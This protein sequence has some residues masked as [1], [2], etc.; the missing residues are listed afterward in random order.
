MGEGVNDME[1]RKEPWQLAWEN[2]YPSEAAGLPGDESHDARNAFRCGYIAAT[3][4]APAV[5]GVVTRERAESPMP[6]DELCRRLDAAGS[7][8]KLDPVKLLKLIDSIAAE[9]AALSPPADEVAGLLADLVKVRDA[10]SFSRSKLQGYTLLGLDIT[11]ALDRIEAF[12]RNS[13][14]R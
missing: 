11:Y 13:G 1:D 14:Q 3:K 10:V 4:R 5:P 6:L 2:A 8:L 12:I 7:R 9:R